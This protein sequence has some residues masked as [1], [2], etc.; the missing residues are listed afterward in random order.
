MEVTLVGVG[1][2]NPSTLTAGGAAA[3]KHADGLIG[4][5]RMSPAPVGAPKVF[6]QIG[7]DCGNFEEA[8][9]AEPL[10]AV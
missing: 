6:H 3:L 8:V 4:S 1:L 2:G 5:R 9:L 10:R 7:R